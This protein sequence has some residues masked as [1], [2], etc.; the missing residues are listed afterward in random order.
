MKSENELTIASLFHT[1][2]EVNVEEENASL[3]HG[4]GRAEDGGDPLKEVVALG[5]GAAVGRRVQR[6]PSQL[7]LDPL[8]R[9][10]ERLRHLRGARLALLLRLL[11]SVGAR[12]R[13][14]HP[15]FYSS[16]NTKTYFTIG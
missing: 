8:G 15:A 13:L 3:V 5:A 14:R 9:G 2:G 1:R 7:L 4:A 12:A 10:G 16:E 11:R 6:D